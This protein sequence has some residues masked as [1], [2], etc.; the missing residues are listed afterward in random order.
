MLATIII[1][2][3]T[4]IIVIIIINMAY[5]LLQSFKLTFILLFSP[6]FPSKS[7]Q[8]LCLFWICL[9]SGAVFMVLLL[10]SL[11]LLPIPRFPCQLTL[12]LSL[13]PRGSG[14]FLPFL[15]VVASVSHIQFFSSSTICVTKFQC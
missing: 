1:I 4:I 6:H 12:P 2:I 13:H 9:P 11:S 15:I 3:T 7:P 14:G 10:C 8:Q 5:S